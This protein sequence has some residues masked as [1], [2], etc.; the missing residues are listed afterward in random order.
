MMQVAYSKLKAAVVD[1]K[2]SEA[3]KIEAEG[4]GGWLRTLTGLTTKAQEFFNLKSTGVHARMER[5]MGGDAPSFQGQR[6]TEELEKQ[7]VISISLQTRT[8]AR[9][10]ATEKAY[11]LAEELTI[12]DGK[13][14]VG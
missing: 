2:M 4:W 3:L 12:L 11:N 14:T 9:F 10:K 1:Q 13:R 6:M 5:F 8:E 7:L